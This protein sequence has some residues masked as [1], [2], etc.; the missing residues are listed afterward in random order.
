MRCCVLIPHVDEGIINGKRQRSV[1]LHCFPIWPETSYSPN[2]PLLLGC[3]HTCPE[4]VFKMRSD[5]GEDDALMVSKQHI[6]HGCFQLWVPS[7][8]CLQRL[9]FKRSMYSSNM[10]FVGKWIA[11]GS[12]YAEHFVIAI[13]AILFIHFV[14]AILSMD[15][16]DLGENREA[17][18][19]VLI[20][21]QLDS[22][23]A[24]AIV[25]LH[26]INI[27]FMKWKFI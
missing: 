19:F 4:S 3:Y 6:T 17:L 18:Q 10:T 15:E 26:Y 25:W 8:S 11:S 20:G 13:V 1:T 2:I 21:F 24:G 16:C 23:S 12:F 9:G 5:V 27:R 22:Q 7:A 14:R